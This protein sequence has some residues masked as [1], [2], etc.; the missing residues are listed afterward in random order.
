MYRLVKMLSAV[1][2]GGCFWTFGAS[3]AF[4]GVCSGPSFVSTVA[5]IAAFV[6]GVEEY[7][8]S[9]PQHSRRPPALS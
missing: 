1:S 6:D 9:T 4:L 7:L 3:T 5:G 8:A 2:G